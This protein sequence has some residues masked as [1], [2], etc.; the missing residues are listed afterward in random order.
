M[1]TPERG[2][3]NSKK[4]ISKKCKMSFSFVKELDLHKLA[5]CKVKQAERETKKRAK[6]QKEK[7]KRL[8]NA[9]N[10]STNQLLP[11]R[12]ESENDPNA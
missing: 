11:D 1:A 9:R 12:K 7:A 8:E 6:E 3:E 5:N 4:K 2:E 10:H